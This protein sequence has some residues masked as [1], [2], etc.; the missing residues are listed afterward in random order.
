[1]SLEDQLTDSVMS[2]EDT[3]SYVHQLQAITAEEKEERARY[4]I[5]TRS[6]CT[7][8][9]DALVIISCFSDKQ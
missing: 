6:A 5:L 2:L 4:F 9:H 7:F 3:R 1:M 8:S